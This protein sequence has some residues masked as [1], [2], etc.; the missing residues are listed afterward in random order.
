MQ[1]SVGGQY[2]NKSSC[3]K[4]KFDGLLFQ[5]E[6]SF[7]LVKNDRALTILEKE[8]NENKYGCKD[9]QTIGQP[10][11]DA[12]ECLLSLK[13]SVECLHQKDLFP[14]NP[15]VLLKRCAWILLSFPVN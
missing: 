3:K 14:Y 2:V 6:K 1:F 13:I 8:C 7:T 15:K 12:K 5:T 4:R 11:K 9:N 10:Y